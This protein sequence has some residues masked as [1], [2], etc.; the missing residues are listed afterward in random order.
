MATKKGKKAAK[1]SAAPKAAAKKSTPAAET[2]IDTSMLDA[3]LAATG[4]VAPK[5]DEILKDFVS[6]ICG[7]MADVSDD[8]FNALPQEARDWYHTVFEIYN[9]EQFD[10]L[11]A[12]PGMPGYHPDKVSTASQQPSAPQKAS[13]APASS[14][15]AQQPPKSNQENDDVA[16]GK[17]GGGKSAKKS[18]SE[19]TERKPRTDG[20]SYK[21]RQAV[22]EN[23]DV[24]FEAL[25]K[26]LDLKGSD[27]KPTGHAH[28][29][30]A[31]AKH[32]MSL[33]REHYA[34]RSK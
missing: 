11:I 20:L 7:A 22:V 16:K 18:T 26:K 1:P 33:A 19:K 31:H 13:A 3:L 23:P 28:N 2:K 12:L 10:K 9:V 4:E 5:K 21:V 8:V 27:A 6:R 32:V 25:C 15:E 30:F 34:L 14:T 24:E 29:M 17:K